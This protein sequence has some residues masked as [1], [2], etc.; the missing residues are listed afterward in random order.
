MTVGFTCAE[1]KDL[2]QQTQQVERHQ[3]FGERSSGKQNLQQ[4]HTQPAQELLH[5]THTLNVIK[6]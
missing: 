5:D 1:G 2:A 3:T 4:T 6:L